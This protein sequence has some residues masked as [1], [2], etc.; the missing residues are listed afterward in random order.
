MK[1]C[2]RFM[3]W[4]NGTNNELERAVPQNGMKRVLYILRNHFGK[5]ILINLIFMFSCIP[6]IT[7]PA[8]L[9]GLNKYL[10]KML[11]DGYGFDLS[12]YFAEFKGGLLKTL[13]TGALAAMLG[14]YGY[15][16]LSLA[17]NFDTGVSEMLTGIGMGVILLWILLSAY[18]FVFH[19]MVDLP[20]KYIIRNT[21]ILMFCE[22]KASLLT[23]LI[24][25]GMCFTVLALMP[26]SLILILGGWFS[27]MQLMVCEIIRQVVFKRIIEPFGDR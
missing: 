26:Y 1:I 23:V 8:A 4:Y 12:I 9:A 13:P 16:L 20:N 18:S 10:L 17:G 22:W 11:R 7:I 24:V 27:V 2:K 14:F 5:I 25:I 21:L 6:V 19:A 15:Y 3:D